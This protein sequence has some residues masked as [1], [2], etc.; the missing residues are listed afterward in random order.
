MFNSYV[1]LP[2]GNWLA[3]CFC[4]SGSVSLHYYLGS[5]G[6]SVGKTPKFGVETCS[7]H[8]VSPCFMDFSKT[9][10]GDRGWLLPPTMEWAKR[11]TVWFQPRWSTWRW[12]GGS[13]VLGVFGASLRSARWFQGCNWQ[14][15]TWFSS[16]VNYMKIL[17][18]T[19]FL[20]TPFQIIWKKTKQ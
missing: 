7:K 17:K 13:G 8:R 19:E 3:A 5:Q 4:I 12:G 20:P 9:I 16:Q 18:V 6:K 1:K 14:F 15:D 10:S 11:R 2:E